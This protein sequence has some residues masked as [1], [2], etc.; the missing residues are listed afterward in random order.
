MQEESKRKEYD[1]V[2]FMAVH[3][4]KHITFCINKSF[5]GRVNPYAELYYLNEEDK[6]EL[7]DMENW[8]RS[9]PGIQGFMH[10]AGVVDKPKIFGM[11]WI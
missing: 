8:H 6:I 2:V 1:N 3:C 9:G 7:M 10:H 5:K 11:F 4:R